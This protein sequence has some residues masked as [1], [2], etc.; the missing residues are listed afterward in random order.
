MNTSIPKHIGI[1]MDGNRRWAKQRG[2]ST[3]QGHRAGFDALIKIIE[4]AAKR[5]VTTITVYAF[6]TE[7]FKKRSATEIADLFSLLGLGLRREMKRMKD[8]GIRLDFLGELAR[9]PERVQRNIKDAVSVLKSNER[10][11]CNIMF[12]YG[13]RTEIIQAIQSLI[14]T[15]K[16]AKEINE[17]LVAQHLYTKGQSDPELIIRTGG[18]MR[19]SNFLLWQMS[20]S[21]LYFTDVLWPD[22]D[23]AC[24]DEALAEYARRSR[25]LGGQDSATDTNKTAHPTTV[26]PATKPTV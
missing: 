1:I 22:F 9:L 7:N 3:A 2:L 19:L 20:Y 11:K 8:A 21:E 13:G 10:I 6:S 25:R 12:N 5:G 4:A 26:Q 16:S 17:E 14:E 18:E 24:L 23:E 15:G